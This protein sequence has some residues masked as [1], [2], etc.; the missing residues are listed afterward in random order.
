MIPASRDQGMYV[1]S[2]RWEGIRSW[3]STQYSLVATE[4]R[5]SMTISRVRHVFRRVG[6]ASLPM[7]DTFCQ[8]STVA[9]VSAERH[10][11][12]LAAHSVRVTTPCG[13]SRL[14]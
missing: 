2:A 6:G 10:V 5:Q 12:V 11:E 8:D 3:C 9:N 14:R 13:R 1:A 7:A 4:V